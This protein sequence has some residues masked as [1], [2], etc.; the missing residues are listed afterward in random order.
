MHAQHSAFII[1]GSLENPT[2]VRWG[3]SAL[4]ASVACGLL[5]TVCGTAG[6][7][8]YLD[9]TQGNILNNLGEGKLAN[10]ARSLLGICM[11][12]VYPLECFVA[13]HV[14][15]VTLFRGRRAH[16]GEDATILNR[17]DRRIS[18][19][20]ALYV[21]SLIPAL[22]FQDLGSVLAATGAVGGSCL[23]YIGPGVTYL[24]VHG[25]EFVEYARNF[26]GPT[27]WPIPS[28]DDDNDGYES[29]PWYVACGK[30]ILW[31]GMLMPL[32]CTIATV[33]SRRMRA[34]EEEVALMSPHPSRIGKVQQKKVLQMASKRLEEGDTKRREKAPLI[35]SGSLHLVG[36]RNVLPPTA[37]DAS[38]QHKPVFEPLDIPEAKLLPRPS[39]VGD[40]DEG[41]PEEDPQADPP[42]IYDFGVA[43]FYMLFGVV[44]LSAGLVSI[45]ASSD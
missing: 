7:L 9:D 12:F 13:R 15:V 3:Q 22:L 19:T 27:Y 6:Y 35:R 44:A 8:G 31:Y 32:W 20:M 43:I 36:E 14:C 2:K 37:T 39:V 28:D 33:G 40:E 21:L 30:S 17:R 23:S 42:K 29:D 25:A 34:H 16:E 24:G 41:P 5:A 11:M 10:L 1:A 4:I 18:L 26:F 38:Y 45:A